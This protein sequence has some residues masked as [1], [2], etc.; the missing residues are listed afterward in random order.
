MRYQLAQAQEQGLAEGR[1]EGRN[2]AIIE[3]ALKL[4]A[5]NVPAEVIAS[6]TGLTVEKV[7][8]L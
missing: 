6:C 2:E 3:M 5:Q 7:Q 4:K 8:E 1:A